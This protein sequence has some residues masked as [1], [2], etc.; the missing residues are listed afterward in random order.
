VILFIAWQL[1]SGLTEEGRRNMASYA[2]TIGGKAA[3]QK[4]KDKGSLFFS[5]EWQRLHGF[6]GGGKRNLDSGS[7]ARLNAEIT[8]N[9]PELRRDAGRKGAQKRIANQRKK[10]IGFFNPKHIAQKKGNLVRWGVVIDGVRVPFKKLSS[11]L[12]IFFFMACHNKTG[13]NKTVLFWPVL[14]AWFD[15]ATKPNQPI[16][17]P[18]QSSKILVCILFINT[19]YKLWSL[20]GPK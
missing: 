5:S 6:K 13:H 19:G 14:L 7:L 11:E 17:E 18:Q 12:T 4:N 8:A 1:M 9:R 2:G 16:G 10:E 15:R 3:N 20:I